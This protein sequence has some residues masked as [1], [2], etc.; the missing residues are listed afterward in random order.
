MKINLTKERENSN[1]EGSIALELEED[2]SRKEQKTQSRWEEISGS[3]L[4]EKMAMAFELYDMGLSEEA[5][6]RILHFQVKPTE[7]S[8]T[9]KK[10]RIA[11]QKERIDDIFILGNNR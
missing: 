2:R 11:T 8:A 4:C 9:A 3:N 10:Q 1:M 7:L 5:V 6:D